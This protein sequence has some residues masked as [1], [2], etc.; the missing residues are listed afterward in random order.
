MP[1]KEWDEMKQRTSF[2][3]E[4]SKAGANI[5]RLCVEYGISRTVGYKLLKRYREEGLSGIAAK[6]RRPKNH[7]RELSSEV[8]ELILSLRAQYPYWGA[9]LLHG[10]VCDRYGDKS[11]CV[12]SIER[13]LS[14][15]GLLV[16][17][18]KPRGKWLDR[19]CLLRATRPNQV[20]TVDFKGWW[21]TRDGKACFPLT[22]RDA[23]SRKMLGVI[24]LRGTNFEGTKE[25]FEQLFIKYGLPNEILSDNGTP[26]ASVLAVQGLTRL[27]AW[28]VKLG[29]RPRRILPGCPFMNGSHERMHRDIKKELQ[30]KPAANLKDE[31]KRFD[32]WIEQY[33]TIRPN[34]ALQG[35]RP[36]QVY[37]CSERK[38]PDALPEYEYP[39]AMHLRRA[40][41]RGRISWHQKPCF[42]A[43]ALKLETIGLLEESDDLISV[44]FCE[45]KLG[46]TNRNFDSP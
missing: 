26:F 30:Y 28:W 37:E 17:S 19:D 35:R 44:W 32:D 24:G 41:T 38:M 45:L 13:V 5:S 3:V 15:H 33:N 46:N 34:Q 7:P 8:R 29:I 14:S 31:Q 4:A 42:V 10:L 9:T 23:H 21:Y 18:R 36:D 40:C 39:A 25:A 1:W 12:R 27:S 43:G 22:V 6:A 11:P 20:W 2:V 16:Q